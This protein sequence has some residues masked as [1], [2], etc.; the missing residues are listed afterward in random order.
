M[1]RGG[2]NG[3]E[4]EGVGGQMGGVGGE[5]GGNGERDEETPED[6]A[7][8]DDDDWVPLAKVGRATPRHYNPLQ[9]AH[10]PLTKS[11]TP[12]TILSPVSLDPIPKTAQLHP[13]CSLKA[14]L[15]RGLRMSVFPV[16]RSSDLKDLIA[17]IR[18]LAPV[19]SPR[20][21]PSLL[22]HLL[23]TLH[24]LEEGGLRGRLFVVMRKLTNTRGPF[25]PPPPLL[26]NFLFQNVM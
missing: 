8:M 4:V 5:G 26:V 16:H 18:V 22:M 13:S 20:T 12:A 21:H 2:A 6:M 19:P 15:A 14:Q 3:Q 24:E 1:G 10:T 23:Y 17:R 7:V 11:T 25:V 9:S